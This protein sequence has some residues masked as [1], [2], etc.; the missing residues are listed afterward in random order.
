MFH[1]SVGFI[2][3][4]RITRILLTGLN[5]VAL[6]ASR[7]VVADPDESAVHR[8][9]S[10]VD[11]LEVVPARQSR[12]RCSQDIVFLAIHPPA[13]GPVLSDINT[14]VKPSAVVVSLAPKHSFAR[15]SEMLGGF[16]RLA[17]MIPNAPTLV[18]AG[19]NPIAYASTLSAEDRMVLVDLLQPLGELPEVAE[20]KLEAYAILTAMGPTY[21]WPQLYELQALAKEFGL[22]REEAVD[23]LRAM[24]VGSLATMNESGLSPEDV[25]D[26][27]P[28]KP[29][30][31]SE[32]MIRQAYR[33]QLKCPDGKNPPTVTQ[34]R[35]ERRDDAV[36]S[37]TRRSPFMNAK[38]VVTVALLS[39]VAVSVGTMVVRENREARNGM[40]ADVTST[41]ASDSPSETG[42]RSVDVIY[43]H[44]DIR[45]PTC[46]RIE[47]YA[48][49]AIE[50]QFADQLAKGEVAW[51]AVNYE[52]PEN[53]HFLDDYQLVAPTV[54][55]VQHR[56]GQEDA[57]KNL[58][59]VWELVSDHTAFTDYI[60]E[61]VATYLPKGTSE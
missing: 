15:L 48:Q 57:W 27:I 58:D 16:D 51:R 59:R 19:F 42:E 29:L 28:V 54:V 31:E 24:I 8:L 2:G 22:S 52:Q 32:E 17:R 34:R 20:E 1:K 56:S 14:V 9:R 13:F 12:C 46:R 10:L 21:F 53:A 37:N 60:Q 43:F 61:G 25:Q 4:G 18:G 50:A 26:L 55:V 30:S 7:I 39:F 3:G 36:P 33:T 23:G 44:G 49:A 45:C 11:R 41:I 40:P 5:R 6:D 47:S 38:T 35:N